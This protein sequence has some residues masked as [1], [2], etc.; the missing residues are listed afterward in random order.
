MF[1]VAMS[2]LTYAACMIMQ[3]FYA[4]GTAGMARLLGLSVT[5]ITVG[6]G[7]PHIRWDWAGTSICICPLP[8]AAFVNLRDPNADDRAP[9]EGEEPSLPPGKHLVVALTGPM[10]HIVLGLALLGVPVMAGDVQWGVRADLPSQP[11]PCAVPGLV[12]IDDT[13]TWDGQGRLLRDTAGEFVRRLVTF[14]SLEDWGALAGI[15]ATAVGMADFGLGSWGIAVGTF[16]LVVGLWNLTP[17]PPFNGFHIVHGLWQIVFGAPL[18]F[19]LRLKLTYVG[20]L[21]LLAVFVRQVYVDYQWI[22]LAWQ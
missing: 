7:R 14:D 21:L 15:A 9:S 19:N 18:T 3:A 11:T 22:R 13:A 8:L 2:L 4:F 5:Q 17:L 10:I 16:F 1:T 12:I 6:L 20:F